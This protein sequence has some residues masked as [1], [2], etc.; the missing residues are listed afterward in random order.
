MSNLNKVKGNLIDL[1]EEGKFDIIVHGCNCQCTMGSGI[2][3][4]IRARYPEAYVTDM[5]TIKGDHDK[6][7]TYS[8]VDT[9][10]F[11]IIN[12]YTQY[13][14][15][16]R[17]KNHFQVS[18]FRDILCKLAHKW[19]KARFG[20]PYIGMGLAGGDA[21]AILKLID[22]FAEVVNSTGGSVTLV[23]FKS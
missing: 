4:E 10:Q 12:A 7:G 19:P 23:E 1:A 17:G 16:P 8:M 14:Y 6:L 9:D 20:F 18:A 21:E 3:K 15:L 11:L 13:H 5:Q 2:A 22:E